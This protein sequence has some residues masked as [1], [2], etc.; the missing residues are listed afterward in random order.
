MPSSAQFKKSLTYL[1][2]IVSALLLALLVGIAIHRFQRDAKLIVSQ[3]IADQVEQL[4]GIFKRI[5][6][7][8]RIV[9][10]D[11]EKN[12]VDFLNVKSF[13][14]SQIGAMNLAYPAGWEG[15]Y[16]PDNPTI[17]EKYYIVIITPKGW[18]IAPDDGI[19]LANGKTIG[20]D[21]KLN[22]ETNFDE[23]MRD[24]QALSFNGRPLASRIR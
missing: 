5:D 2:P 11:H 15:P 6:K 21:I 18:F 7:A 24:P 22:K 20:K 14:G 1:L 23:L 19:Q 10:F 9:G 12:Y 13:V 17:N 3:M 8:C 16:L 4:A